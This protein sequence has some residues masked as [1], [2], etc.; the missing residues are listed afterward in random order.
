M[1]SSKTAQRLRFTLPEDVPGLVR[2][3]ALALAVARHCKAESWADLVEQIEA[4]DEDTTLRLAELIID[5]AD[6]ALV[7]EHDPVLRLLR[8]KPLL[9]VAVCPECEGWVLVSGAAPTRCKTTLR[10]PGVKPVK[11]SI[12]SKYKDQPEDH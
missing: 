9:T 7:A 1:S 5:P 6:S 8:V 11:A 4:G 12:A 10:C 3:A 2:A